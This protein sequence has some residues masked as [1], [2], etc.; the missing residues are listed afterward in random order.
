VKR[1]FLLLAAAF[2]IAACGRNN[3]NVVVLY[4][5]VDEAYS[6]PLCRMF[7]ERSGITVKLVT[8]TE[9]AKSAGLVT[10]LL[11]EKDKPQADLF[12][13]GDAMRAVD[14][15]SRGL[16]A[17][18]HS[19]DPKPALEAMRQMQAQTG[20]LCGPARLR[21]IL[22]HKP[23]LSSPEALPQT[24]A[25]LATPRF[26]S[27]ACMANP[28]FGTTSMH[29]AALLQQLGRDGAQR[30]L[31]DFAKHGG[32]MLAS[33]GEV[34]RRVGSGEF[35]IGLT[36]SDDVNVALLDSLPVGFIV[37]DQ[38]SAGAVLVPS[39]IMLVANAPHPSEAQALAQFLASAETAEWMANGSG[40]H[41]PM[42]DLTRKPGGLGLSLD[43]VRLAVLDDQRLSAEFEKWRVSF[44]ED[45]VRKQQ[46]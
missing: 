6:R 46:Y 12:W 22:Y 7:T 25:D 40:A 32:R 19:T 13:S 31:E 4:S 14:L 20:L 35:A 1:Q 3:D 2:M 37:P 24:V 5:S 28:L 21:V 36:D 44:L 17:K 38:T 42:H 34:K 33:N 9:A 11:A 29:A 23:S 43:K 18:L 8:D 41:F 39:A 27:R 26:A 30:F 16:A 15:V 10:R 45:W